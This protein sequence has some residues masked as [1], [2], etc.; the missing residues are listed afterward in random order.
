MISRC[1]IIL[2]N[3]VYNESAPANFRI[4]KPNGPSKIVCSSSCNSQ[5]KSESS[6]F[7]IGIG[8]VSA[9]EDFFSILFLNT[10]AG[11]FNDN[12]TGIDGN[13]HASFIRKLQGIFK[14]VVEDSS[15]KNFVVSV[16]G[17][18]VDF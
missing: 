11:I 15:D 8:L 13:C 4:F 6:K 1:L 5:S 10:A 12:R 16:F 2:L 17:V 18:G 14:K 7:V 9:V 3:G